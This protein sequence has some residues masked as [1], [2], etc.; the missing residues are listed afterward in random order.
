MARLLARAEALPGAAGRSAGRKLF[1]RKKRHALARFKSIMASLGP[2]D[3]VLDLGANVG[4]MTL[5]L[6]KTGAIVHAYEPD[7]DV[8]NELKRNLA[9]FSN[10]RL[11]PEAVAAQP[12][13]LDFF[14]AS[15]KLIEDSEIRRQSASLLRASHHDADSERLQ[16]PVIAFATAIDRAGG[17]VRLVKMDIEGAETGILTHLFPADSQA[18]DLGLD[19]IFVETHERLFPEHAA[20]IA[21]LRALADVMDHPELNLYWP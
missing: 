7:P 17:H 10:V 5:E 13:T 19:H 14:R 11:Y 18:S 4:E 8:F 6:V 12:G 3:H 2:D 9:G 21:R 16:V 1:R 20:E 15:E